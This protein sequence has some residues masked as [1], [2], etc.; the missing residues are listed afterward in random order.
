MNFRF[1]IKIFSLIFIVVFST[2]CN[3]QEANEILEED[4]SNIVNENFDSLIFIK[5]I[6]EFVY[7]TDS[8]TVLIGESGTKIYIEKNCFENNETVILRLVEYYS[9]SD[10]ILQ[11]LTTTSNGNLIESKGMIYFDAINKKNGKP[12]EADFDKIKIAFAGVL[13]EDLKYEPKDSIYRIFKGNFDSNQINWE[14]EYIIKPRTTVYQ[15]DSIVA[16]LYSNIFNI[17]EFGWINL[18][19]FIDEE[20]K[21]DLFVEVQNKS[22]EIQYSLVFYSINSIISGYKNNNQIKFK[23]I[24]KNE[25]VSL[26]GFGIIENKLYYNILDLTTETKGAKFPELILVEQEDLENIFNEKFGND[27]TNRPSF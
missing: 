21:C 18:D 8:D 4:I 12:I 23:G 10:F 24:P 11:G 20:E 13:E 25:K 16:V 22:V 6:Q 7:Q 3:Q 15:R 17:S 19:K 14:P 1:K 9:I 27:L 5:P 26:I 2:S